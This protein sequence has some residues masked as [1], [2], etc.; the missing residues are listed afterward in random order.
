MVVMAHSTITAGKPSRPVNA[1]MICCSA[2]SSATMYRKRVTS[3][4]KNEGVSG[5]FRAMARSSAYVN[6]LK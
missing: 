5:T 4:S 1:L 3:L 6:R 2:E